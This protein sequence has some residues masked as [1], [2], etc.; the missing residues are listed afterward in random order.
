MRLAQIIHKWRVASDLTL[1]DV[2]KLTGIPVA[3]LQRFEVGKPTDGRN[4]GKILQ[5][6]LSAPEWNK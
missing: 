6:I 3:S 4:I 5:F 1:K 2:A